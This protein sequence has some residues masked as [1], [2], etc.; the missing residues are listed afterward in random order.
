[1]HPEI[2]KTDYIDKHV[3]YCADLKE[4]NVAWRDQSTAVASLD[5]TRIA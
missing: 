2:L 1:M 3:P 5:V 4:V